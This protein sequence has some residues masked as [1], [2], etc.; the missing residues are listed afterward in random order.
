M[1]GQP[2]SITQK[3]FSLLKEEKSFKE[4]MGRTQAVGH[5]I[6]ARTLEPNNPRPGS[7]TTPRCVTLRADM[8]SYL[9][10]EAEGP[11]R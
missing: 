10:G 9:T 2:S 7:P 6:R 11:T 8:S 4:E 1:P 5:S 3:L